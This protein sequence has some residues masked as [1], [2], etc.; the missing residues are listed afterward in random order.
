[1]HSTCTVTAEQQCAHTRTHTSTHTHTHAHLVPVRREPDHEARRADDDDPDGRRDRLGERALAVHVPD[2]RHRPRHVP[3]LV[4]A[5]RKDDAD[6]REDLRL[7]GGWGRARG[8]GGG[9]ARSRSQTQAL[10]TWHAAAAATALAQCPTART[11]RYP[12]VHSTRGSNF[13]ARAWI[14]ATSSS[15]STSS[16]M[17]AVTPCVA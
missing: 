3:D 4:R 11:C 6:R 5:V 2:R 14:C 17:S 13:S 16:S 8:G 1:M 7:E 10:H 9:E 15:S 12:N